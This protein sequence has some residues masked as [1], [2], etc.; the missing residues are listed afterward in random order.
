M[1][2]SD[3]ELQAAVEAYLVMLVDEQA[4]RSVN[5]AEVRRSLIQGALA[6]R[7]EGAIEYRMQN[8]S[9]VLSDM[10]RPW[11]AGYKP[12]DNLGPTNRARIEHLLRQLSAPIRTAA[13]SAPPVPMSVSVA[14]EL[15]AS[16]VVREAAAVMGIKAVWGSVSSSG[17]CFGARGSDPH[18]E[19]YFS[20]AASAARRAVEQ[21]FL[22]T[23]GAG[24]GA[25][26]A[27]KHRAINLVEV[28]TVYGPTELILGESEGKRLSQW[29][30]ASLAHRVFRFK[31]M[32]HFVHDLGFADVGFMS[33][34]MDGVIRPQAMEAIWIALRKWPI[35]AVDLLLPANILDTNEPKLI[36]AVPHRIPPSL[37]AEEGDRRWKEQLEIERD[38]KVAAEAKRLNLEKYGAYTC[39]ACLFSNEDKALFD[40]HHPTP[41]AT[42]R[43]VTDARHLEVLCP[44]CH[45]RAH[46]RGHRLMPFNLADLKSWVA[47]GRPHIVSKG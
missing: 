34:L 40:A 45:R 15:T 9:S 22:I 5:K 21:P 12:A 37:S 17:I 11:I 36:R 7:S 13:T 39:E 19:S 23:V 20:V 28:G 27:V 14:P 47:N 46:R 41:L 10:K 3:E 26:E 1:G 35:E 43:R 24:S 38:P 30:V 2:W 33:G 18:T 29:P 8:I 4:G 32:P 6:G 16:D 31:G 42:G 44:I 25:P